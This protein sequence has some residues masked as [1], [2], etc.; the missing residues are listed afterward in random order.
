MATYD[1]HVHS[2][3]HVQKLACC[4]AVLPQLHFTLVKKIVH[5][6]CNEVLGSR[7]L[8]LSVDAGVIL[9]VPLML[10][11]QLKVMAAVRNKVHSN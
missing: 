6:D 8:L 4:A 10:R 3:F 9:E 2:F 1:V 11:D 7:R 5:T